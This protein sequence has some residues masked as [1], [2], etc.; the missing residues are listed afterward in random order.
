[1]SATRHFVHVSCLALALQMLSGCF[2]IHGTTEEW[3]NDDRSNYSMESAFGQ[4]AF[5]VREKN[6]YKVDD[7]SRLAIGIAPGIP[8][9]ANETSY[10]GRKRGMVGAIIVWGALAPIMNCFLGYPTIESLFLAPFDKGIRMDSCT[11]LG[12][13]GCY[14]WTEATKT[15]LIE[16]GVHEDIAEIS[17]YAG[18]EGARIAGQTHDGVRL[19][20]EY[21]GDE[22]MLAELKRHEKVAVAFQ[23]SDYKYRLFLPAKHFKDAYTFKDIDVSDGSVEDTQINYF[24]KA[25]TAKSAVTNVLS[26]KEL[27]VKAKTII[28]AAEDLLAALPNM[29]GETLGRLEKNAELIN[30]EAKEIAE[31]EKRAAKARELAMSHR[32]AVEQGWRNEEALREFALRESPA[33][34]RTVQQLRTE[35]AERRKAIAQLRTDLQEFGT[36]P[37]SDPDYLKFCQDVDAMLDSLAGI[38]VNLEKA[39]IAAKKFEATPGRNDYEATMRA[40]LEGGTKDAENAIRRF[41]EMRDKK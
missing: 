10:K 35:V 24:A 21:P 15:E 20:F 23:A 3:R 5:L 8:E 40:A 41:K 6:L 33:I 38:F 2:V 27:G 31:T 19:L 18:T 39:Y 11:K 7:G 22:I 30:A 32:K 25:Q 4:V 13:M 36:N 14:E 1:M 9:W 17:G 26:H 12:F 34:W 29:D 16:H 28:K 37:D